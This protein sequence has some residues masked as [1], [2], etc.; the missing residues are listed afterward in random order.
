MN[1]FRPRL[2]ILPEAQRRL[3]PR[4]GT[5]APLG[6][7]LYGGTAIALRFGHRISVDFNFFSAQSLDRSSLLRL[8]PWLDSA[9]V[10][11]DQPETLTL[12]SAAGPE[13]GVKLSF[14]GG[15]AIGRVADPEI[16]EDGVA[17]VAS[18]LDLLATKLKV[19]LQRAESKDYIDVAMLL[20]QGLCLAEG[21]SAAR[22]LDGPSFPP[23]E[24]LKALSYFADGDLGELP[25]PIRRRLEQAVLDVDGLETLHR[26]SLDLCP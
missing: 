6:W 1:T 25:V 20:D 11:Q 15:L 4:L 16:S 18:P 19:L 26:R 13:G 21:L 24:A 7:V 8:C 14:F 3:W 17:W 22:A 23:G 2:E 5:L 9:Q 10:L 12:I